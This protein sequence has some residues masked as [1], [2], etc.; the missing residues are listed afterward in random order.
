M[1]SIAPHQNLR[2]GVVWPAEL[3]GYVPFCNVTLPA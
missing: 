2:F 3:S 1:G